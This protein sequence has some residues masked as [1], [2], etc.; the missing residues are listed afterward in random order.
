MD[1]NEGNRISADRRNVCWCMLDHVAWMHTARKELHHS[2]QPATRVVATPFTTKTFNPLGWTDFA[3]S[4]AWTHPYVMRIK[5]IDSSRIHTGKSSDIRSSDEGTPATANPRQSM[6]HRN[7]ECIN[8]C[9]CTTSQPSRKQN[10]YPRDFGST[11]VTCQL[12]YVTKEHEN[13][14]YFAICPK[15]SPPGNIVHRMHH[16]QYKSCNKFDM[17]TEATI[18]LRKR[19]ENHEA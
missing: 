18:Q 7:P 13:C 16:V 3:K 12:L 15:R 17:K 11:V 1:G 6:A 8:S 5:A 19:C 10:E 9:K 4:T 2:K 14:C